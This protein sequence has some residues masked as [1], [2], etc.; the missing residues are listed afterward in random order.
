MVKTLKQFYDGLSSQTQSWFAINCDAW[1]DINEPDYYRKYKPVTT[2]SKDYRF[3]YNF[4]PT[5]SWDSYGLCDIM[6]NLEDMWFSSLVHKRN[7]S[8]ITDDEV[9]EALIDYINKAED[10]VSE[11]IFL[12]CSERQNQQKVLS[13]YLE[14]R[15]GN[16][17]RYPMC[18]ELFFVEDFSDILDKLNFD[19]LDFNTSS[20]DFRRLFEILGEKM[21][22]L[23]ASEQPET[24]ARRL[25][26]VEKNTTSYAPLD[27]DKQLYENMH[28]I[29]DRKFFVDNSWTQEQKAEVVKSL[30]ASD[31]SDYAIAAFEKFAREI[32]AVDET[33][34]R[35]I[36]EL[37]KECPALG[38]KIYEAKKPDS[39]IDENTPV[40]MTFRYSK[41]IRKLG[42][43][44]N[45]CVRESLSKANNSFLKEVGSIIRLTGYNFYEIY[46]MLYP[47][48]ALTA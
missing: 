13:K 28:D 5:H 23:L 15:Y 36:Y 34:K 9:A 6:K 29:F 45:V 41:E 26:E 24:F 17:N 21:L 47:D 18:Y 27:I 2:S 19:K 11:K 1:F 7:E 20:N 35:F 40:D 37:V 32:I 33:Y 12:V 8:S 43:L 30:F 31:Y 3:V 22:E 10:N 38:N 48:E 44:A 16:S 39:E 25:K 46:D 14:A 4:K 42:K